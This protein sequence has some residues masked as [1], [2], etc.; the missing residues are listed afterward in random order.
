MD[1]QHIARRS[2]LYAYRVAEVAM[3]LLVFLGA[4][5]ACYLPVLLGVSALALL[6]L[7]GNNLGPSVLT[8]SA[9]VSSLL[10]ALASFFAFVVCSSRSY[11]LEGRM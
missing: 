1:G 6:E 3:Y 5:L 7:A 10:G 8:V 4:A 2:I 9:L 11:F